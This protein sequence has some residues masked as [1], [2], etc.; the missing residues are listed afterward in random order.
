MKAPLPLSSAA[1]TRAVSESLKAMLILPFLRRTRTLVSLGGSSSV[2]PKLL[3]SPAL[4]PPAF[5]ATTR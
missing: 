3:P 2:A 1:L 5:E 4:V